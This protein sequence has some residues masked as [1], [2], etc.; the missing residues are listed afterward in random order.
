MVFLVVIKRDEAIRMIEEGGEDGMRGMRRPQYEQEEINGKI[1]I[2]SDIGRESASGRETAIDVLAL[3]LRGVYEDVK[4]FL[5]V[6]DDAH[7]ETH[8][9]L[10]FTASALG[11]LI[12]YLDE[13]ER[14]REAAT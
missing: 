13:H 7:D 8:K 5:S 9:R 1:L 2:D 3:R 10:Y 4:G 11:T 6:R 12:S 14:E